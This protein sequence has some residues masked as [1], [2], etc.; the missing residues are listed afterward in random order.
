M[1]KSLWNHETM[2]KLV[3]IN[4]RSIIHM[5]LR[6]WPSKAA[7]I[8]GTSEVD[9]WLMSISDLSLAI[10]WTSSPISTTE[11]K[12]YNLAMTGYNIQWCLCYHHSLLYNSMQTPWRVTI[13]SQY[14]PKSNKSWVKPTEEAIVL[15]STDSELG[16]NT[17]C[18]QWWTRSEITPM[19]CLTIWSKK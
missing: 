15:A 8:K 9:W 6:V 4:I 11:N 1:K 18:L 17:S 13:G 19:L 14:L 3:F 12:R 5:I 2:P 7:I 16:Y 10:L